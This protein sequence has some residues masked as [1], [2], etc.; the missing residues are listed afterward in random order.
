M[1]GSDYIAESGTVAFKPGTTQK[2][3]NIAITG[4]KLVEPD[5][6]FNVVLRNSVRATIAK[7]AGNGTI[8][9]DDGVLS[10]AYAEKAVNTSNEQ[11]VKALPNPATNILHVELFGYTGNIMMQLM[12]L[13]G[14]TVKQEKIQTGNIKYAQQQMN[15]GDFANGIFTGYS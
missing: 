1:S 9:N 5:E 14:K 15:V 11:S 3:I 4:D 2:T 10:F 6:I 12:S 8:L 7:A 13:Q